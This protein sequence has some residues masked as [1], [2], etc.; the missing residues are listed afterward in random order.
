[1]FVSC[2]LLGIEIDEGGEKQKKAASGDAA[3]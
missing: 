2:W 1:M 3:F